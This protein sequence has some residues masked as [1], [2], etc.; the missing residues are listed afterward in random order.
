MPGLTLDIPLIP[1]LSSERARTYARRDRKEPKRD[2]TRPGGRA[3][4]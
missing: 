1:A 2:S 3:T 4:F